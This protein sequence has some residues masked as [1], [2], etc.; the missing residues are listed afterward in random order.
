VKTS[1]VNFTV[2]TF[3]K[4]L[5]TKAPFSGFQGCFKNIKATHPFKDT[6]VSSAF[7][8]V[9]ALESYSFL[10]NQ[11]EAISVKNSVFR[12]PCT[13]TAW[14]VWIMGVARGAKG[15]MA[16]QMFRTYRHFVL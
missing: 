10:N 1:V 12:R 8:R 9:R 7:S 14:P 11:L 4:F 13:R 5:Q 6:V 15:A 3:T 2:L 16:P